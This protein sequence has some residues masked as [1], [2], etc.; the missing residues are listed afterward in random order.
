M[1]NVTLPFVL[2]NL[3]LK[4]M[5]PWKLWRTSVIIVFMLYRELVWQSDCNMDCNKHLETDT[6]ILKSDLPLSSGVRL[7][8]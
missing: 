5:F 1:V 3:D 2:V 4:S 7:D 6:W 8:K